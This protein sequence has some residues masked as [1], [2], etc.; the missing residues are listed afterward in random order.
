M[1]VLPV[2]FSN[3]AVKFYIALVR[4]QVLTPLSLLI[5]VATVLFSRLHPTSLTPNFHA[6]SAYVGLIWLAQLGYC[7]LLKAM[8]NAVGFG[9]VLPICL[10]HF[11]AVAFVMQW[12]I[13]STILQGLLLLV[14]LFSNIVLLIYHQ[15]DSS[16]PLDTAL[17][18]AP[19][20]FFLMLPLNVLFT[21]S[22]FIS[23]GL[24]YTPT[25]PGPPKNPDDYHSMIAFGV[26][27][28][29][30]LLSLLVIVIRR[31][32]VC[33][34]ASTWLAVSLWTA[35]P[36]PASVY[37]TSIIFTVLHP[38]SL[39]VAIC[40][41]QCFTQTNRIA[42]VGDERALPANATEHREH[43]TVPDIERGPREVDD[44]NWG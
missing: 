22:L 12:F 7:V 19:L 27:M 41:R 3:P 9:L 1:D 6:I 29:T 31:D 35:V 33:C 24:S 37:I 4:L 15:P 38:L 26:L 5:N 34:V 18:H 32:I 16:R 11:G 10:W 17:I 36:K 42:L 40:Y 28:G 20:R 44:E 25:P 8:V 30:N 21:L 13:I 14:L 43:P 2:D 23:L 39:T